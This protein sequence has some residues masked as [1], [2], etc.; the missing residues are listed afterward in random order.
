MGKSIINANFFLICTR[1]IPLSILFVRLILIVSVEYSTVHRAMRTYTHVPIAIHEQLTCALQCIFRSLG[2]LQKRLFEWWIG[3][4]KFSEE[5]LNSMGLCQFKV[6]PLVHSCQSFYKVVDKTDGLTNGNSAARPES[7][8]RRRKHSE[9]KFKTLSLQFMTH[10][11]LSLKFFL[12]P[13]FWELGKMSV[14]PCPF[15]RMYV[16]M[17]LWQWILSDFQH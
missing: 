5:E 13:S 12:Q 9:T 14:R 2:S 7:S 11:L 17:R 16:V 3:Q 10:F 8:V 1:T 6:G 15:L 4:H